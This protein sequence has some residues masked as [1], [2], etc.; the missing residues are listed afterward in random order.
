MFENKSFKDN[1]LTRSSVFVLMFLEDKKKYFERVGIKSV[2]KPNYFLYM[3][4]I[5]S[6]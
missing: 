6:R 4:I 2:F 1:F 3:I 5:N